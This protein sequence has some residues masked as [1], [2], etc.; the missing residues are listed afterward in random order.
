MISVKLDLKINEVLLEKNI[1]PNFT[2][3]Y[4]TM[5]HITLKQIPADV[6]QHIL[7]IQGDVKVEKKTAQYSLEKTVIKMLK[8]HKEFTDRKK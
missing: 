1:L 4:P 6:H 5:P 3:T 7:K 8:E 2:Q